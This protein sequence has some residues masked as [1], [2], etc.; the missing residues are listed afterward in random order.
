MIII[1]Q[2]LKGNENRSRILT[3]SSVGYKST[4][5]DPINKRIFDHINEEL[6]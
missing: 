3:I 2:Q 1:A 4:K 5:I 6:S